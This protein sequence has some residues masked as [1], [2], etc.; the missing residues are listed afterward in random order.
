MKDPVLNRPLF[1]KKALHQQQIQ[2]KN[3][4]GFVLGGLIPLAANIGRAGMAGLRTFRGAQ[5][6][7]AAAG[8]PT[9]YGRIFQG[10]KEIAKKPSVAKGITGLEVATA[11][12]GTEELRRAVMDEQS[13]FDSNQPATYT[14]GLTA[15]YGGVGLAGRTA[16]FAF[17]GVKR[18]AGAGEAITKKTPFAAPIVI[19]GAFAAPVEAEAVKAVREERQYRIPEKKLTEIESSLNELQKTGKSTVQDYINQI[20]KFELTDKQKEGVYKVLGIE[21]FTKQQ[22]PQGPQGTVSPPPPEEGEAEVNQQLPSEK[23][24]QKQMTTVQEPVLD[25]SKMNDDERRQLANTRVKQINKANSIVKDLDNVTD[26]EF[27]KDFARIKNSINSVTGGNADNTNLLLLKLASGLLTGKT[28]QKGVAGLLDI[29]GQSLGPV[30]DTAVVLQQS[31]QAFDQDLALQLIKTRADEA[32]NKQYK[33]FKDRQFI[34]EQTDDPV[35]GEIG[36]F[37]PVNEDGRLLDTVQTPQGEVL[38]ELTGTNYTLGKESQKAYDTS[39]EQ[40]KSLSRAIGFAQIVQESPLELIG[41]GGRAREVVDT[42]IGA[43]KSLSTSY[44]DLDDFA[45]QTFDQTIDDIMNVNPSGTDLSQEQINEYT[46]E[47]S[48]IRSDFVKEN[49]KIMKELDDARTSKNQEKLVRAQLKLIEQRMKYA[50]ANANKGTDRLTKADIDDAAQNTKIFGFLQ[51]PD[52]VKSNYSRIE[53]DLNAQFMRNAKTYV[54]NGGTID[55]V[56]ANYAYIKPIND[57]IRRIETKKQTKEVKKKDYTD[58]LG[59]I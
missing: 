56:K 14:G 39:S 9:Q 20:N 34:V 10:A 40:M 25:T 43:G 29:T 2:T 27:Q 18:I 55:G 44:R 46:E 16:K 37:V 50:I 41:A 17:P 26:P 47:Q 35:F 45:L 31:Q 49:N 30:V 54:R 53:Q 38:T 5:A 13:L 3:I 6:A 19:G 11:G 33:A 8:Q 15:L 7:R 28:R 32:K 12:A 59:G 1:R 48:E 36:R 4:P 21:D 57:Y 52:T 24:I 23:T 22:Q 42:F 58:V 51:D